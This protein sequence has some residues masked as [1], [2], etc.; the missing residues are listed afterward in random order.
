MAILPVKQLFLFIF[1]RVM[2][3]VR[4]NLKQPNTG[5]GIN[6]IQGKPIMAP[7]VGLSLPLLFAIM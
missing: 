5:L 1:N 3:K 6:F 4:V 7:K 2:K